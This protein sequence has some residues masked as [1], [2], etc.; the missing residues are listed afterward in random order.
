MLDPCLFGL[1]VTL[2]VA[3]TCR[4]LILAQPLLQIQIF[5]ARGT[6]TVEPIR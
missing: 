5:V 4:S 3:H 2:T 1:P 6:L